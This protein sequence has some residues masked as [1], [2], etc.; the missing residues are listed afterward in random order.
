M[1]VVKNTL[2]RRACAETGTESLLEHLEGLTALVWADGDAAVVAKALQ[3]FGTK[4]ED[5]LTLR[6][7]LL[8]G[9]PISGDELKRLAA[10]PSRDELYTRLVGGIARPLTGTVFALSN[11]I[12]GLA[13]SLAAVQAQRASEPARD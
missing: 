10:L 8:D 13:R 2:A 11:L 3:E 9:T 5:R 6:G 7:G 1:Q 12:S 4:S